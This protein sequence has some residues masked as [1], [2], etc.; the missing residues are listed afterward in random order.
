[1]LVLREFLTKRLAIKE[2]LDNNLLFKKRARLTFGSVKACC[3]IQPSGLVSAQVAA[4]V[5]SVSDAA[6]GVFQ[7]REISDDVDNDCI[8]FFEL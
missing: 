7:S 1:M 4:L 6:Q 2:A 5:C 3:V 8:L